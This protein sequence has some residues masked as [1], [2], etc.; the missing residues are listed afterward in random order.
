MTTANKTYYACFTTKRGDSYDATFTA[1]NLKLAK[2]YA[3]NYKRH[4][5]IDG[6]TEVRL[7]K[8]EVRLSK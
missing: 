2:I 4:S 1:D 3:Q 7:L 6:R 8:T 5:K